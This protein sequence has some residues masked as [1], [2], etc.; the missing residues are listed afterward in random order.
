MAFKSFDNSY[1]NLPLTQH[2]LAYRNEKTGMVADKIFPMLLVNE[3]SGDI[4]NYGKQ[5]MRVVETKRATRGKYNLID[6]SVE[7]SSHYFLDDY[8]LGAY[9]YEEDYKNAEAP[10]DAESDTSD[11]VQDIMLLDREQRA[12]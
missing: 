6:V 2:S 8:G 9:V 7:K 4:Y 11:I 5:S 1:T 12:L 10:L 3:R